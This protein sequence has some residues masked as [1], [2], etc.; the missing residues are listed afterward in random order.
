MTRKKPRRTHN[1]NNPKIRCSTP[2]CKK[3]AKDIIKTKPL[4]RIHSP[5]RE[6]FK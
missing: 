4:C 2:K 5:A 1:L 6:G 3:L